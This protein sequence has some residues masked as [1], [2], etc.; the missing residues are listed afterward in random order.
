MLVQ[1]EIASFAM[2]TSRNS[3]VVILKEVSGKR[4]LPVP[5]GP[6]EASAIAIESLNVTPE[7]PLTIDLVRIILEQ[8]GGK[9]T[10]VVIYDI[11]EQSILSRLQVTDGNSMIFID[12]RTSDAL[13]LALRCGTSIFVKE[14][15]MEKG[16]S[17]NMSEK[18]KLRNNISS[19]DTI[20]F[21]RFFLE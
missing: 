12:C 16:I 21:G 15:V 7:K 11:Q 10:R 20:E 6:L 14:S 8:L 2:D 9:L 1:V 3:P 4:T 5:V 13:A 18:E 19:I 17:G